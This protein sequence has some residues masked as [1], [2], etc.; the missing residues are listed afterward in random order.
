[1]RYFNNN[2][3]Y[4]LDHKNN[5]IEILDE[6]LRSEVGHILGEIYKCEAKE[7]NERLNESCLNYLGLLETNLNPLIVHSGLEHRA[8]LYNIF[9]EILEHKKQIESWEINFKSGD[10]TIILK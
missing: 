2:I 6:G 7:R 8:K 10:I 3:D 1:M 5:K 4:I 9:P